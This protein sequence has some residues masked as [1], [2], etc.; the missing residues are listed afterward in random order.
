MVCCLSKIKTQFSQVPQAQQIS[1][2]LRYK[3]GNV[4]THGSCLAL[5]KNV[6]IFFSSPPSVYI[7]KKEK[8]PNCLPKVCKT[9]NDVTPAITNM[10]SM[11]LWSFGL[12]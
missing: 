12:E 4:I 9:N 5:T 2:T 6:L 1:S 8:R 11:L 7:T 10:P 3:R